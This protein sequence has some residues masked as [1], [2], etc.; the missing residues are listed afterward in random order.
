MNGAGPRPIAALWEWQESAACRDVS[1]TLFF[2]PFRER[3]AARRERE[4]RAQKVCAG[5]PVREECAQ[6]AMEIGE[7]H[8]TWGG[9]TSQ[10]RVELLRRPRG[11]APAR[12][13]QR[14]AKAA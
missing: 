6:F 12:R 14:S 11:A 9:M 1:D 5:C 2:S 4:A 7:E 3:G 13:A 10:E 8:G